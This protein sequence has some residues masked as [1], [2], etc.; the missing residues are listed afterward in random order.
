MGNIIKD[1]IDAEGTFLEAIQKAK[2][3]YEGEI[4]KVRDELKYKKTQVENEISQINKQRVRSAVE[5]A[6]KQ[7]AEELKEI[8]KEKDNLMQDKNLCETIQERVI[9]IILET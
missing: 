2:L 6:E 4:E 3:E 8:G 5:E 9:S 7:V 1:I